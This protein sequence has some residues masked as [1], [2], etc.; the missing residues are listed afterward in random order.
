MFTEFCENKGITQEF[1]SPK[2]PQQNGIVER[3]N[4]TLQEMARVMLSKQ[5]A[6]IYWTKALNTVCHIGTKVFL[7]S[8]S[9]KTLYEIMNNKN[10]N[11]KYFHVFWCVCYN[12]ND[13][14]QLHKFDSKRD[15]GFFFG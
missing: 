14:D 3:K 4:R 5:L 11:L 13:R 6:K 1:S 7:R 15:K 12:L 9:T 2:T 8:G 10:P